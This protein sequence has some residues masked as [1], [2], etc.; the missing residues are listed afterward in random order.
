MN[1]PIKSR[2][3]YLITD[4]GKL[5]TH[6]RLLAV[7]E[8]LLAAEE[9]EIISHLQI[10]EQVPESPYPPATARELFELA[11]S[12]RL[13][14]AERGV[15]LLINRRVDIT[16]ASQA[17]GVHLGRHSMSVAEARMLLGEEKIIGLS[18]HSA[19][20]VQAA[21]QTGADYALLSPVFQPL[22]KEATTPPL[23]SEGVIS[24]V[25]EQ[26]IPIY[27]LGGI[28]PENGASCLQVGV[29][30]LAC[31]SA[32]LLASNPVASLNQFAALS[33]STF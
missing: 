18:T 30:G 1:A 9:A 13:R 22:S 27:A 21:E 33:A 20:E 4:G 3:L 10:R 6:G 5:R 2:F 17:D 15:K 29:Q 12:L 26:R 14:C 32:V 28:T 25:R 31:I 8:Q 19:S 23:G 11:S 16:I 24:I 7:L